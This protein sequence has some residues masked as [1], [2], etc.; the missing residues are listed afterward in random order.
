M[1]Q[2]YMKKQPVLK[3]ILSMAL[4]MVISMM[5]SSLYNIVDSFFI[6]KISEDAMTALS[7]VYPVQ[8]L[9]NAV[10]IGFGIG[11][12]AVIS[13]YLGAQNKKM[14]D[15]AATQ[16]ML[17]GT[18]HG[19]GFMILGI[20]IM[21]P[22]LRMFTSNAQIIEYGVRYSKIVFLFATALSW[23]LVFEKTFQAVGRMV[24]SMTC[25]M[26]GC[27]INIVLDPVMIFGIGPCP[28][29]GIEGAAL[30]TGIGQAAGALLYLILYIVKP[31]PVKY[32]KEYL[33]PDVGIWRK[34]YVIGIPAC[35]NMALP[36]LLISVLN[37][38]LAGYG[39]VY[40][41][42]LGVY[43]KLQTFLYLPVNGIVQGLRPLIG[44]NYGAREYKRVHKI[45]QDGL[46][47]V[48]VMMSVGTIICFAIPGQLIGLFTENAVTIQKG[49]TALKVISIGFIASSVSVI[50][51]GALEGLR[52]GMPSL[53]I[54][55]CRYV[56]VIIPTAFIVSHFIGA[57]GVWHLDY[58]DIYCLHRDDERIPVGE[59][60][61]VMD[62]V[63]KEG[64]ARSI[65]VS[66]WSAKRLNEAN[67][68]ARKH[69]RTPFTSSQIQWNMAHCTR[70]DMLDKTLYFMDDEEYKL[71]K[72]NKIPVM[73][74]SPQAVGFFS[75][76]LESGEEKLSDRAKMYCTDVNKK[77]AEKVRQL[78]E[79]LGCSP[80]ALCVAYI[81]CN[82]VD[83]YAVVS[84]ST[85]KQ[86][87][88]TLT[89][90]DLK[91]TQDMID[92]ILD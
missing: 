11:I 63:V 91:I 89:G 52:K 75:K 29:L 66:N 92:W 69:N 57:V 5:V 85:M 19:I 88:D 79:K 20:A 60:V 28:K 58:V 9:I 3:L 45:F 81:T 10:M 78:C 77:R 59:I 31:L 62:N 84:N 41:F 18:I 54:S 46:I 61:D 35:L 82:P 22:F 7:L 56:V 55:L 34:L 87:E 74:Y 17:L 86:M 13:F 71:Y 6:A 26:T 73:A 15:R 21:R 23:Q 39:E 65:G 49:I 68:Y 38:I 64:F 53:I 27:I 43:Y 24:A 47:L 40:V 12:N 80:A 16:G 30:A 32:K 90:V 70:E 8:N 4:P 44:Y 83:G 25:M 72:E 50:C 1:D 67:E 48:L 36:S 2:T 14:A 33:K 37:V 76:Y 51:C 42:V